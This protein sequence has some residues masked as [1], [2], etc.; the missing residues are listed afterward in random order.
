MRLALYAALAVS[1]SLALPAPPKGL[2]PKEMEERLAK[3]K[4]NGWFGK[5]RP[6]GMSV[7]APLTD[8]E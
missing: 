7:P 1:L 4:G 5:R 3:D 2:L 6:S 8:G